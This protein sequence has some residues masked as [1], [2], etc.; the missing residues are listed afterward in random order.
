MLSRIHVATHIAEPHIETSIRKEE[1]KALM[2]EMA[3][4]TTSIQKLKVQI[5]RTENRLKI[6]YDL[7]ELI[8]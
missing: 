1:A 2:R 5:I 4:P 3:Y 8:I 7:Y 6:F